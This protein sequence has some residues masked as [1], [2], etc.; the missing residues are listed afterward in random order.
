MCDAGFLLSGAICVPAA[1]CGCLSAGRYFEPGVPLPP[2][3]P[4][5]SRCCSCH[6]GGRVACKPCRA[7]R[8]GPGLCLA[9][10]ELRYRTFDG[11]TFHLPD[12]CTYSLVGTGMGSLRGVWP[13]EVVLEKGPRT[14]EL[15]RVLLCVHGHRFGL[16]W[17]DWGYIRVSPLPVVRLLSAA[18]QFLL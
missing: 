17:E 1:Q 12:A 13:F 7:V 14:P 11:T 15:R 10:D 4:A 5:T 16:D 2:P 3:H 6:P 8:G 9:S 18:W